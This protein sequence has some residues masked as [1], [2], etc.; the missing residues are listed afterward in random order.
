MHLLEKSE[1]ARKRLA[2][3]KRAGAPIAEVMRHLSKRGVFRKHFFL[4]NMS[5]FL[6]EDLCEF[7]D[8]QR[9]MAVLRNCEGVASSLQP[10]ARMAVGQSV[11]VVPFSDFPQLLGRQVR[12]NAAEL[13]QN[14]SR[15][16]QLIAKFVAADPANEP[17]RFVLDLAHYWKKGGGTVA[18]KPRHSDRYLNDLLQL[19]G[20]PVKSLRP[21]L[22]NRTNLKPA[23]AQVLLELFLSHW[24]YIGDPNSGEIGESSVELYE[25]LFSDDQIQAVSRYIADRISEADVESRAEAEPAATVTVPGQDMTELMATE[26]REATALFTVGAGQTGLVT[27]P[28]MVLIG[29]RNLMDTLWKIDSENGQK[30][31]LIWTLDLGGQ[32]FDDPE[33]RVKFVNVQALISRFKALKLFKESVTEARWNWLQSRTIIVLHDT[34]N[35][36]RDNTLPP[37]FETQH[38]LFSA[39]PPKW[40]GSPEFITLYGSERLNETIYTVFLKQRPLESIDSSTDISSQRRLECDLRFF[41]HSLLKSN[42]RAPPEVR[43]LP[44][45]VPGRSYVAAL[46]TVLVAAMQMLN[47]GVLPIELSIN[48]VEINAED[49]IKKLN[50]HGLLLLRLDQF[51]GR[52]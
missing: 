42:E 39:I 17:V 4:T 2:C 49:A 24:K 45:V 40:A 35:A 52:Y 31:V 44:L 33:S 30:R 10:R 1:V 36:Q 15:S 16:L 19:Q 20:T 12:M 43:G 13:N 18:G 11:P 41:G 9:P 8:S 23:D 21:K 50:H 6:S 26:F 37:P 22:T 25:P 7:Y 28:D 47:P 34:R 29:F 38:V 14:I 5:I 3:K 27:S 48:D 46:G 32:D 51:I